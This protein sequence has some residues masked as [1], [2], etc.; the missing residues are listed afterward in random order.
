MNIFC[1]NVETHCFQRQALRENYVNT[2]NVVTHPV[3]H[4]A[5]IFP[6][7]FSSTNV[8]MLWFSVCSLFWG[9]FLGLVVFGFGFFVCWD[10]F[11]V[12]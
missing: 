12:S 8:Y 4:T 6:H 11:S 1:M 7:L 9:V 2:L 5:H 10:L 3:K